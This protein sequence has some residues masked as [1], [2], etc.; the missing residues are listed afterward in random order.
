MVAASCYHYFAVDRTAHCFGRQLIFSAFYLHVILMIYEK[1]KEIRNYTCHCRRHDRLLFY[2][3]NNVVSYYGFG[4]NLHR[5]IFKLSFFDHS[6]GMEQT[7]VRH[8]LSDF[9][10]FIVYYLFFHSY[11]NSH[12]KTTAQEKKY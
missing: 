8:G 7:G 6:L 2:F 11:A 3:Q 1:G 12:A 10:P 5:D 9:A 4:D